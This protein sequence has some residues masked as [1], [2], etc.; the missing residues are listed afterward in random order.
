[1]NKDGG[2]GKASTTCDEGEIFDS[3]AVSTKVEAQ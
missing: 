1:M 2:A 3:L